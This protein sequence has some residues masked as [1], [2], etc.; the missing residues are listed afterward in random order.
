VSLVVASYT[1]TLARS[2]MDG[3]CPHSFRVRRRY[4]TSLDAIHERQRELRFRASHTMRHS[5]GRSFATTRCP[6]FFAGR[7]R[8]RRWSHHSQRDL[9][10][11]EFQRFIKIVRAL[12]K[13]L[14][15]LCAHPRVAQPDHSWCVRRY[16]KASSKHGT[17]TVNISSV[18]G[19]AFSVPAACYSWRVRDLH[20]YVQTVTGIPYRQQYLLINGKIM[21][22]NA[23]LGD[24]NIGRCSTLFLTSR[25][26]GGGDATH[27]CTFVDLLRPLHVRSHTHT[28]THT[29]SRTHSLIH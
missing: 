29:Y 11:Y 7:R 19:R 14:R 15:Q 23:R 4:L 1:A 25:Q 8:H 20:T 22:P 26:H 6:T 18:D 3:L 13:Q 17:F 12:N 2:Y 24:Y 10:T 5:A 27:H 21:K 28:H 16:V 9:W